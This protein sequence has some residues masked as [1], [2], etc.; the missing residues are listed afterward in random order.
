MKA[1]A[2][3]NNKYEEAIKTKGNTN[4]MKY[5]LRKLIKATVLD[6]TPVFKSKNWPYF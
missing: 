4:K 6:A 1:I 5:M 2:G 3:Q